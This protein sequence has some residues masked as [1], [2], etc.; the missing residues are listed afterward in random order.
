MAAFGALIGGAGQQAAQIGGQIRSVLESRRKDFASMLSNAAQTESDPETR[1]A[2]LGHI[3]DLESGKPMGKIV[4]GFQK[5]LQKRGQDEQALQSAL[6]PLISQGGQ[7]PPAPGPGAGIPGGTKAPSAA[8]PTTNPVS[9]QAQAPQ[10]Q[11]LPGASALDIA[12]PPIAPVAAQPASVEAFNPRA[13]REGIIQQYNARILHATPAIRPILEQQLQQELANLAPFEQQA[14]REHNFQTLSSNPDFASLPPFI[15][16]AYQAQAAG[17][18][19][20]NISP[21]LTFPHT[22]T[23]GTLGS[24][25]PQGTLEAGTNR[26]VD[27]N[28]LYE[29]R[30]SPM[31]GEQWFPLAPRTTQTQTPGGGLQVTNKVTGESIAPVQG[32]VPPALNVPINTGV[33][34]QG[35][36]VFQTRKAIEDTGGVGSGVQPGFIPQ[37]SQS[38][39]QVPGQLPQTTTTIRKKGAPAA[40]G[41][42]SA[43]PI[44]PIGALPTEAPSAP[45][46]LM[47]QR[48]ADWTAGKIAPTGKDLTALESY[49]Q[50]HGLQTPEILSPKGQSD[51]S[52][53]DPILAEV[54]RTRE[55]LRNAIQTRQIS[56]ASLG[57]DYARYKYLRIDSPDT[58][59]ISSLSFADL[60]SA[61]QA[62]KGTGSRAYQVLNRALEHTPV[63]GLNSDDPQMILTKLNEM[64]TRLI[65]GRK[66]ILD[67]ERKGGALPAGTSTP[68]PSN[69]NLI[70]RLVQRH[71]GR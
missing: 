7:K 53:I 66:A 59:L 62:L 61:A 55:M 32:A 16:S 34:P 13:M 31:S 60:R 64:E 25:A 12:T 48:F 28:T 41:A 44:A 30:F 22:I 14:L 10:I 18:Q 15:K 70:D 42:P 19:P 36:E 56:K 69:P 58:A 33:N 9:P 68:A 27:P 71:G 57:A 54:Q 5:T 43:G 21:G 65:E 63:V 24:Q 26:P 39:Q 35:H 52:Q 20:V 4:T 3:A 45:S 29:V 17:F 40:P 49:A 47:A 67:E 1:T 8:Q 11:G 50:A 6:G 46:S 38:V 23:T 37:V 51:L 2:L